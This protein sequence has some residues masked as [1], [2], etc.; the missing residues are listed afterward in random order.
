MPDTKID[1]VEEAENPAAEASD[2]EAD[3]AEADTEADTDA[4]GEASGDAAAE[5]TPPKVRRKLPKFL[6]P[7]ILIPILLLLLLL[8]GAAMYLSAPIETEIGSEAKIPAMETIPCCRLSAASIPT[9]P[10]STP[11]CSAGTTSP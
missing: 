9:S 6:L 7:A 11:V 1:P 5:E 10:P 2:P 8:G 4:D 3:P